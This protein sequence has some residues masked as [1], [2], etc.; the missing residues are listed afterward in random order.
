MCCE[1][2]ARVQVIAVFTVGNGAPYS[3]VLKADVVS[4]QV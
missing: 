1:F 4:T 3:L 2:L